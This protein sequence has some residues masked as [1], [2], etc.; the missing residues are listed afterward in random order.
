LDELRKRLDPI[1]KNDLE[2]IVTLKNRDYTNY[3]L[4]I[5]DDLHIWDYRYI[6]SPDTTFTAA[7]VDNA[8]HV[9]RYYSRLYVESNLSLDGSLVKEYFPVS[10]VVPA[11]LNIYQS[12]LGVKFVE[13]D[14]ETK[15]VWRPGES[16][17]HP[18]VLCD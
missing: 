11:I 9:T 1:G 8:G 10:F 15:D 3:G 2:A 14:G 16:S 13:V 6:N 17:P 4:P 5:N 18:C 7:S 12:L